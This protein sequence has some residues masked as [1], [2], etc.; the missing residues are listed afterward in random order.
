MVSNMDN[1]FEF[2]A[3]D[4]DMLRTAEEIV[5]RNIHMVKNKKPINF[6]IYSLYNLK[7]QPEKK[8]KE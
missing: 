4:E 7:H 6:L 2:F 3:P 1:L 8:L 5:L